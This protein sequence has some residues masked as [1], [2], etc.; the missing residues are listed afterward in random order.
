MALG[1]ELV[2]LSY[3]FNELATAKFE[4]YVLV[5][6]QDRGIVRSCV[7]ECFVNVS[8]KY[9]SPNFYACVRKCQQVLQRILTLPIKR[10][11][12]FDYFSIRNSS[13]IVVGK[14][15]CFVDDLFSECSRRLNITVMR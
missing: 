8:L 13:V 4:V 11:Q 2:A 9:S 6:A 3:H 5:I 10:I 14:R 12:V 7:F 1:V 15:P